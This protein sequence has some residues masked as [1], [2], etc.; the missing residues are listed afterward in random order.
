MNLSVTTKS[1]SRCLPAPSTCQSSITSASLLG[2]RKKCGPSRPSFSVDHAAAD[3]PAR[4]VDTARKSMPAGIEVAALDA[5]GAAGRIERGRDDGVVVLAPDLLLRLRREG[6]DQH[7][8]VG[9]D[10]LQPGL[11]AVGRREHVGNIAQHVPAHL[12][13]AIARRLAHPQQPGALEILDRLVG[14]AALI[15]AARGTLLEHG[16][17]RPRP[18]HQLFE[19]GCRLER[20]D[21]CVVL[22]MLVF[23]ARTDPTDIA[24]RRYGMHR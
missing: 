21:V 17:Q 13:A 3:Q 4:E 1:S 15:L 20:Y 7:G 22:S 23:P 10:V 14:N 24:R 18:R 12:V 11:R 16:H 5:R 9:E 19:L 8:V 2:T 6:R